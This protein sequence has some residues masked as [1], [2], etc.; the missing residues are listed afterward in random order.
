MRTP[1]T[2]NAQTVYR[3]G[4]LV[5][6]AAACLCGELLVRLEE[7]MSGWWSTLPTCEPW[8]FGAER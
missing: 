7:R 3:W 8:W 2:I 6:I 5:T 1:S 4:G